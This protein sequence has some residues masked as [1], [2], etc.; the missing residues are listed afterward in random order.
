[1]IEVVIADTKAHTLLMNV[2]FHQKELADDDHID[3]IDQDA[4]ARG[5]ICRSE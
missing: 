5:Y 3:C 1:M 4:L 2:L